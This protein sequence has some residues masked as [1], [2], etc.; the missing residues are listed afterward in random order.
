M[1][2]STVRSFSS[3]RPQYAGACHPSYIMPTCTAAAVLGTA[4][5]NARASIYTYAARSSRG[6]VRMR[7]GR[8]AATSTL[9]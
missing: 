7:A 8:S 5:T 1:T 9:Y 6:G 2:S 3:D 4:I